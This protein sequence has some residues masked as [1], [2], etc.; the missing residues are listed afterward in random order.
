MGGKNNMKIKAEHSKCLAYANCVAAAP[1]VYDLEGTVVN[2]LL[3]EP[4]PELIEAARRGARRCPA[5]ALTI[6]ENEDAGA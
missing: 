4:P 1:E 2:V 3:P 5:K 6:V